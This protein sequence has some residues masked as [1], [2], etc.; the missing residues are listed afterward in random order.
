MQLPTTIHISAVCLHASYGIMLYSQ[1]TDHSE[2]C[3][4]MYNYNI[5]YHSS[6]I[7]LIHAYIHAYLLLVK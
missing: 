1:Y 4:T 2:H 5:K 7:I 6:T 3:F